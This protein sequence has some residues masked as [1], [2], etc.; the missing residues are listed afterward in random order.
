M[1]KENSIDIKNIITAT[2][3][4][5]NTHNKQIIYILAAV[6][7]GV[8]NIVFYQ[9]YMMSLFLVISELIIL[10][11]YL[12]KNNITKYV[13]FYLIFLCLSLEFEVL[14]NTTNFYGFKNF[15]IGGINLGVICLIP[16]L[17][18]MIF[19][20]INITLLK[21][22]YPLVYRFISLLVSMNIIAIFM[23]A[24]NILINDNNIWGLPEVIKL[25]I[26]EIYLYVT[27]P[28]LLIIAFLY[29]L[30]FETSKIDELKNFLIAIFI[31]VVASMA[32]S[33]MSG[34]MGYYGDIDTLLVTN[35]VRYIPFMLLFPFY[36]NTKYKKL[37]FICA[38]IGMLLTLGYNAT[39]KTVLLYIII[40][41]A[42]IFI[43]MKTK[44]YRK[45]LLIL[46]IMPLIILVG[47]NMISILQENSVLFNY[48][49]IQATAIL[50]IWD[51]N[52]LYS[53]P[54]SPR[55]RVTEFIN[56]VYEYLNKPLYLLFGKGYLGSI[57]D[58]ISAFS[59]MPGAFTDEQWA[60][61][62][63]Y[64]VHE[65]LNSIFL[66]NGLFGIYVFLYIFMQTVKNFFASPWFLCG[67]FW[68]LMIYGFSVTMTA[69]GLI[70]LLVGYLEIEKK[71]LIWRLK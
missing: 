44:Q 25:F 12:F 15:R 13:G 58:H 21:K 38:V 28:F 56:I 35:T 49:L 3:T 24:W 69:F 34:N 61:G 20:R 66:I 14:V 70:C 46:M 10:T 6:I 27:L 36:K 39:G 47:V 17:V 62:S 63:F 52:W 55:F 23:G 4:I 9:N 67:A 60:N 8:Y 30:L 29:L 65:T 37:I 50:N 7:V 2:L 64:A 1:I 57:T 16:I 45:L 43:L 18:K 53:L 19:K 31:G 26:G 22:N 51:S 42:I 32:A 48:K 71:K 33:L 41:M 54:D 59:Y 68:F 40:P 5:N 11:Y